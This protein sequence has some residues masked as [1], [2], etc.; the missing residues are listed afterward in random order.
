M[1]LT[2]I[3]TPTLTLSLSLA[4]TLTQVPLKREAQRSV[5]EGFRQDESTRSMLCHLLA[6]DYLLLRHLYAPPP[7]CEDAVRR[8]GNATGATRTRDQEQLESQLP[9]SFWD[10]SPRTDAVHK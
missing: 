5:Y 7:E 6:V 2:Q 4:L 9:G 10:V 8:I 3:L 1:T